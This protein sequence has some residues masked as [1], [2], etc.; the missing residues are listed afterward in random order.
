MI[1]D[2]DKFIESISFNKLNDLKHLQITNNPIYIFGEGEYSSVVNNFLNENGIK[3]SAKFI[4]KDLELYSN[5]NKFEF[6]TESYSIVIGIADYTKAKKII[7]LLHQQL[8]NCDHI[9]YFALNP[10]YNLNQDL[11][12]QNWSKIMIVHELLND[13]ISNEI[14][15]N[16]IKSAISFN[17]EYL[18][19][20]FPQYFP[21]FFEFNDQEIVIDG[22][23]YVGD[24]LIEFIKNHKTFKEYHAFE[25]SQYNFIKLSNNL[26]IQNLF[27]YNKGVGLSNDTLLFNDGDSESSTSSFLNSTFNQN[28]LKEVQIVRLD[29]TIS[30]VSF[31][32]LDIEGAELDAL[33]GS[34]KLI[35]NFKP[36]IAVCIY[37]K[38]EHLWQ[39]IIFLNS[40]RN[41][42]KFSIRYHSI[43]NILTELVLYA[44]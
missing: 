19:A 23:A 3:I 34:S 5:G 8:Q 36:K 9:S 31:I 33:I 10:F 40:L 12:N 38:F 39:I 27:L 42:Y 24:T 13:K 35:K 20:T 25:P 14:L 26:N 21:S 30:E 18:T 29:D 41:D 6:N 4:S 11:L 37:H 28:N 32:K 16:Y 17:N 15:N 2:F 43:D 7:K 22:G 44:Y 1:V